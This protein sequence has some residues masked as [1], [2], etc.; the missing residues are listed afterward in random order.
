[1]FSK[2]NVLILKKEGSTFPL[3]SEKFGWL[4][5]ITKIYYRIFAIK[6]KVAIQ[7]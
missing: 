5:S 7:T 6:K 4:K 2:S 3:F 1:M